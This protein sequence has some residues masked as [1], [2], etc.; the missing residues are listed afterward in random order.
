MH[1]SKRY[2]ELFRA[3]SRS[4][5]L[6]ENTV[7]AYTRD[8]EKLLNFVQKE[9]WE[10]TKKDLE[11][12]IHQCRRKG[13][14]VKTINRS[15][16]AARQF[17]KFINDLEDPDIQV[18]VQ[19]KQVKIQKQEYLEDMLEMSDFDR[20][21]KAAEKAGDTRAVA[22]FYTLFLTGCR[23]SELLQFEP[24]D[25]EERIV[26][27]RGKGDKYREIFMPKK[28]REYLTAYLKERIDKGEGLF[29]GR[30]GPLTRQ[31]V[32]NIIKKYAGLARVKLSRAHAH[33]F[34]HLFCMYL[35]EEGLSI[36]EIADLAGHSDINITRIYTRKTKKELLAAIN[37]LGT[38]KR[39]RIRITDD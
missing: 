31:Q 2:L 11:K 8:I 28:A 37:N 13:L 34:R 29:T 17:V 23:I 27:V 19:I 1:G 14:S 4:N 3:N 25:V 35:V 10:I 26:V 36:D 18:N 22:I 39:R 32:H 21:V 15:L 6:S 16:V 30:E 7:D 9:I 38:K 12:Y 33:N 20:M 5:D 24:R